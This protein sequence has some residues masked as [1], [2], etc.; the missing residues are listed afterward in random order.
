M[1]NE[2]P[3]A[4]PAFSIIIALYNDWV[5]LE[6]CLSSLARQSLTPSFEVVV[7]D[8]GSQEPFP[9]RLI[10]PDHSFRLTVIRQ[11]HAGIAAARNR[12]IEACSGSILVFIDA[13]CRLQPDCLASLDSTIALCPKH[14]CFQL[15]LSGDCSTLVGRAEEL[16]LVA[17]QQ[18]LLQADG[19]I[20][21]L[22]TAGFA[23]RRAKVDRAQGLFDETVPRGEDTVLLATL[24]GSGELPYFVTDAVV[25][26]AIAL[27]LSECLRKDIRTVQLESRAYQ[28]IAA[29]G[30]GIR[31]SHLQRIRMLGLMWSLA[32]APS[33]G[34]RAWWVVTLRQALQRILSFAFRYL[35]VRPFQ[36]QQQVA[37]G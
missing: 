17:L 14:N 30:I 15:R 23:I 32:G 3:V 28:I 18:H 27:K 33:I 20:A 31:V 7:I 4:T 12:G 29:K 21:Y 22:N 5:P 16:R 37:C 10:N 25:Q 8:D 35:P 2:N 9:E 19:R 11:A 26:H 24:M 13:D 1:S 36:A 34:R 6:G